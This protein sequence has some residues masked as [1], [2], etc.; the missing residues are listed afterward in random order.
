[1][2]GYKEINSLQDKVWD[3]EIQLEHMKADRNSLR[4]LLKGEQAKVRDEECVFDFKSMK[5]FSVEREFNGKG[6]VTIIGYVKPGTQEIG[7]WRLNCN[8]LQHERLV[9]EFKKVM[10]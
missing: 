3:L 7:E 10:K 6:P 4:S 5:A 2:F 8:S 9:T 1:M